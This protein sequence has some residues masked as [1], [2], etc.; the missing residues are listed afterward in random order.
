MA[1]HAAFGLLP[2]VDR[3]ALAT[4]IPTRRSPAVLLDA[5]ATVGCRPLHLV[6]FAVMGPVVYVDVTSEP[7]QPLT[8]SM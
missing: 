2:G 5:G 8:L 1:A 7:P 4:I 6:Q 3:P